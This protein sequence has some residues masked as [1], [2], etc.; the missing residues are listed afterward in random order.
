MNSELLDAMLY[1]V[2]SIYASHG[3]SV[4]YSLFVVGKEYKIIGTHIYSGKEWP[5]FT[6]FTKSEILHFVSSVATMLENL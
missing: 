1:R 3:S 5:V 6:A 2:N 4:R